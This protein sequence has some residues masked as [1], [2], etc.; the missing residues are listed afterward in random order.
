M[1]HSTAK[2][3]NLQQRVTQGNTL[4]YTATSCKKVVHV[5]THN[6]SLRQL[7]HTP[8]I[9]KTLYN[10]LQHTATHCDAPEH[11]TPQYNTLQ[12]SATQFV[13]PSH[14]HLLQLIVQHTAT[15]RQKTQHNATHYKP[16]HC[17]NS[18]KRPSVH[19]AA[20]NNCASSTANDAFPHPPRPE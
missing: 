17:A 6:I 13:V 2:R 18:R 12:Q 9:S 20:P 3:N 11:T 1:Q 19:S 4:Q 10:T 16:P 8:S 14:T 15:Q 5:C 7:T